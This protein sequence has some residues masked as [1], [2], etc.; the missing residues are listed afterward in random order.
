MGS[1]RGRAALSCERPPAVPVFHWRRKAGVMAKT[2]ESRIDYECERIWQHVEIDIKTV[3]A[4]A[5]PSQAPIVGTPAPQSCSGMPICQI[6]LSGKFPPSA[7][8]L[9]LSTGCPF[10]DRL[11]TAGR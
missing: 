3:L 7:H 5:A 11:T 1:P 9:Q 10:M 4:Y 6:F 2:Y 8:V